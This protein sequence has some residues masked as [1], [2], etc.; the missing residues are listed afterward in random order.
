VSRRPRPVKG[1]SDPELREA[2]ALVL[3]AHRDDGAE[4]A[5]FLRS[6]LA[7]RMLGQDAADVYTAAM[8]ELIDRDDIALG[9]TSRVLLW[10]ALA[11]ARWPRW[12]AG[13]LQQVEVDLDLEAVDETA[14][15]LRA[16]GVRAARTEAWKE[17]AR[18]Q[19]VTVDA[20]RK[21][22]GRRST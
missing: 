17:V 3:K 19:G 7:G 13:E 8:L 14:A 21:R 1:G 5:R 15:E 11:R 2:L 18:A 16:K 22:R 12:W 6:R 20:L 9:R 4:D 10:Y